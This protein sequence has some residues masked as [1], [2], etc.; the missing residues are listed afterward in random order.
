MYPL[1]IDNWLTQHAK[2]RPHH[3]AFVFSD[4]R[5]TFA[6]LNRSVNRMANALRAAGI[7]KGDKVATVLPNSRELYEAFWAVAKVGAVLVPMSPM[8]R[9]R[10]LINLLNDAD[11]ALVLTDTA[12][13]PYLDEVRSELILSPANYW[14]TDGD[15]PG[16]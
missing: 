10:G 8:V 16:W 15:Q 7:A 12:H 3:V 5:L 14:L 2:F 4:T 13:A 6:A 1:T 11:S 9:G